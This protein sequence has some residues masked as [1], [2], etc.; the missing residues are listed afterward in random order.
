MIPHKGVRDAPPRSPSPAASV[1]SD[2]VRGQMAH[3]GDVDDM[4][5]ENVTVSRMFG[6]LLG[7]KGAQ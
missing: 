4:I 5:E 7:R 1:P 6:Q 2:R 3:P